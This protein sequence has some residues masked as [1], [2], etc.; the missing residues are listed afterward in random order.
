MKNI[1]SLLKSYGFSPLKRFSQNFLTDERIAGKIVDALELTADDTVIEIGP[2]LGMLTERLL[3]TGAKVVVIEIDKGFADILDKKFGGRDNFEKII[4]QDALKVSYTE[5]SARYGRKF[6]VVSN[7]P[8]N[9]STPVI[10]K[11]LEQREVFSTLLLMLQKEVAQRIVSQPDTKEYGVLSVFVQLLADVQIEFD[12]PPSCFYPAPKVYSSVVRFDILDEP[13]IKVDDVVFFKKVVKA[14]FGQRRK[15][16]FNALKALKLPALQ[17][18]DALEL[19]GIDPQ[20]RG[21]TL[22]LEEFGILNNE[23]NKIV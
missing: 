4:N 5:L 19:S 2:G 7:L 16:L 1:P 10:F 6:K 14:S 15:T 21:E 11:L 9:I 18:K 8:Y 17:I 20:R 12:V 23:L 13:R 22:T 3:D